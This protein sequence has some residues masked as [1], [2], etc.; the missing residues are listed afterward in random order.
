MLILKALS[1]Q[2]IHGFGIARRIEQISR[3]VFKVNPGL[4]AH[5]AQAAGARGLARLRVAPDRELAAGQV[6]PPHPQRTASSSRSRPRTGP[7]GSPPS[8]GCSRRRREPL[9][10]QPHAWHCARWRTAPRPTGRSPTRCSTTSS[11]PPRST[12]PAASRPR[13]R[14]AAAR[15]EMGSVTSGHA[16]K[17]GA[18]AGRTRSRISSPTCASPP[19][20]SAA[21]PASPRSPRSPWPSASAPPPR[22]SARCNPILFQPLPYPE[23]RSDRDAVGRRGPTARAPET[24]FGT[25]R[26][27]RGTDPLVQALAVFKPWQPTLTGPAEPERLDGQRVERGLLPVLGVPPAMGRDFEAADDRPNAPDVVHPERRALA[28]PVRRRSR[29]HRPASHP[30]RRSVPRDR[31]H[32]G[33]I[34]E[35]ARRLG[36]GLDAA[37][38]RHDGGTRLGSS[39]ADGRSARAGCRPRG[40]NRELERIA[41]TPVSRSSR[42]RSG[43]PWS[44]RSA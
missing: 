42:D 29:D 13:R 41:R 32:A 11:R 21:S 1:L 25:Y 2:P 28:P 20:G 31:R 14:G 24:T 15:L 3:G 5:R 23:R 22:S 37:A 36:R 43:R 8:P 38:V 10:R 9:W 4:A 27:D 18:T 16:R 44:R 7:A 35:R 39:P 6:L 33:G 40:A 34:R 12:S 30:R 26:G 17:Y 19:A